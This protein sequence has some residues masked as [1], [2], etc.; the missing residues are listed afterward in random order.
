MA[1]K[2]VNKNRLAYFWGKITSALAG[3]QATLV[4]GENIK[5][6]NGSSLLGSGDLAVSD[7][8]VM[9]TVR[10]TNGAFPIL[11]RGTSAGT[12]T[13]TTTASFGTAITANPSTGKITA[14]SGSVASGDATLVTGGAVYTALSNKVR[15]GTSAPASTLGNNGDIYVVYSS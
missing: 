14:T 6:V 3:K 2:L 9:Q 10:T 8:K 1:E 5:S 15:Y 12:T 7:T 11:L 4:S 13:T